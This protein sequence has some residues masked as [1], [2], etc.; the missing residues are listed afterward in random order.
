MPLGPPPYRV[1]S[2]VGW[3]ADRWAQTASPSASSAPTTSVAISP[4]AESSRSSSS[5]ATAARSL[6]TISDVALGRAQRVAGQA[7]AGRGE[8]LLLGDG[9]LG[10]AG[11]R[12]GLGHGDHVVA[13]A[14]GGV[15]DGDR[16]EALHRRAGGDDAHV[17]AR[18]A[19]PGGGA[20][21]DGA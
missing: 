18:L 7:A 3:T 19:G 1:T 17:P 21:G 16:R 8:R 13:E 2:I 9:D 4:P 10:P 12:G 20:G 6:P 15:G 5:Q 14:A 11:G